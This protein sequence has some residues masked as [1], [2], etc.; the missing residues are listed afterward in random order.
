MKIIDCLS[1]LIHFNYLQK[2]IWKTRTTQ[3]WAQLC[4]RREPAW[5]SWWRS[6]RWRTW[7]STASPW[8]YFRMSPT[9]PLVY[10]SWP[11]LGEKS[12][13]YWD[14]FHFYGSTFLVTS[15]ITHK[16]SF[17]NLKRTRFDYM[18]FQLSFKG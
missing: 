5:T 7:R 14:Y 9:Q 13:K 12:N 16:T 8:R 6:S 10:I 18:H 1:C 4:R 2:Y 3:P 15:N 11:K 17:L